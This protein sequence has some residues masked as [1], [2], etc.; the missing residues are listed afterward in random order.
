MLL[1]RRHM[2]TYVTNSKSVE[3]DCNSIVSL[4]DETLLYY[5]VSKVSDHWSIMFV[6]VSQVFR[7]RLPRQSSFSSFLTKEDTCF[8]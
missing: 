6:K 7:E 1:D 8:E 3:K 2:P 5:N 4:R